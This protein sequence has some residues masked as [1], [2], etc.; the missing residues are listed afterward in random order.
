MKSTRKRPRKNKAAASSEH[1]SD[2]GMELLQL[3]QPDISKIV[4]SPEKQT[5]KEG[6]KI[7]SNDQHVVSQQTKYWLFFPAQ[8]KVS[9]YSI[10]IATKRKS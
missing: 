1:S 8:K 7:A 2:F 9:F 5:C 6:V 4:E 10:Y 3:T